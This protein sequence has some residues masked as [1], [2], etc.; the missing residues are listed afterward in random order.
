MK[1]SLKFF[2]TEAE[3]ASIMLK[4]SSEAHFNLVLLN[5]TYRSSERRILV[6]LPGIDDRE[7]ARKQLKSTAKLEFG[8]RS[9]TMK[10]LAV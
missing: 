5:Q 9:S 8:L 7:R 2:N 6:E 3:T 4:A 1:K 10:S